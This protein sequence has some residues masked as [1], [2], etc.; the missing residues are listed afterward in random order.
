MLD[1]IHAKRDEVRKLARQYNGQAV[2]VFGS[3]ARKEEGADSDIDFLVDFAPGTTLLGMATLQEKLQAL[4]NRSI[5]IVT[6]K[7]LKQDSFGNR[8]RAE[9]VAI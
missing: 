4:F 2:Y 3:C 9:R 5:D 8:V 7:S 1:T 6:E